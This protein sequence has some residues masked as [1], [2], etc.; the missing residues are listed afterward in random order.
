MAAIKAVIMPKKDKVV[1]C[2]RIKRV[3]DPADALRLW[4]YTLQLFK[5]VYRLINTRES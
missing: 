4:W 3:L 2:K 1:F 5:F